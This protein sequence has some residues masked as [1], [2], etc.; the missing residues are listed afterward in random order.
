MVPPIG[1]LGR[2][3][4]F[5]KTTVALALAVSCAAAG[6]MPG[7]AATAA[8]RA[9]GERSPWYQTDAGAAGSRAN[10]KE[11]VLTPSTVAKAGF[12]RSMAAPPTPPGSLCGDIGVVAPALVGGYLY[13]IT[14]HTVSKYNAAT[15]KLIW[16][17]TPDPK[18]DTSFD[19]LSVSPSG[20]VVVGG[21]GCG[22]VSEP[23]SAFYAYNAAS[24]KLLWSASPSEGLDRA[25]VSGGYVVTAGSDAAGSFFYVLSLSTGK[26]VWYSNAGC[27]PSP[28]VPLVVGSLAMLY[29]CDKQGNATIEARNLN[30]GKL[31]WEKQQGGWV[32]Q[33]GDFGGTHLF[34]KDPAGAVVALDPQTGRPEYTLSQAVKVLA[35]DGSRA[36]AACGSKGQ[37]ACAYDVSTGALEWRNTRFA[38]TPDLAAEAGGVLY[39][40]SFGVALNAATGQKIKSLP[41]EGA[42]SLAVGDGRIAAVSSTRVVD[43]FGLPGY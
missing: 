5:R 43:L 9:A 31:V 37:Y 30:T 11:N 13:A 21:P 26:T 38:F 36:Y 18:F 35:V 22:S 25:V 15:G 3:P 12:L 42:T 24:G 29:G 20:V 34:A 19:S 41:I 23:G 8:S 14:N 7:S 10:L 4:M 17:R 2:G 40:N 1:Y 39:L 33:R 27:I 16:R 6:I 28:S 32:L